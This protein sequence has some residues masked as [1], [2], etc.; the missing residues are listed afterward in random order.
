[1]ASSCVLIFAVIGYNTINIPEI[2]QVFA[3]FRSHYKARGKGTRREVLPG[4]GGGETRLS[5]TG[6][7]HPGHHYI[8]KRKSYENYKKDHNQGNVLI[9]Q[10]IIL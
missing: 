2:F 4:G 3:V 1:M 5:G 8:V 9:F 6:G 7:S 10:Q